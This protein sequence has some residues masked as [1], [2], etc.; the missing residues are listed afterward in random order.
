MKHSTIILLARIF[1]IVLAVLGVV[2]G[3]LLP[4]HTPGDP[5]LTTPALQVI[6]DALLELCVLSCFAILVI[7]WLLTCAIRN[8]TVFT[9]KTAGLFRVA[10]FL[11]AGSAVL[12]LVTNVLRLVFGCLIGEEP[13]NV[14]IFLIRCIFFMV[15]LI[16]ALVCAVLYQYLA[17]AV[18]LKEDNDSIV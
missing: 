2:V 6:E 8:D 11:L 1:I 13:F 5:Y 16:G 12:Y 4:G 14:K 3:L 15:A 9:K 17:K 10:A 18:E 7:G